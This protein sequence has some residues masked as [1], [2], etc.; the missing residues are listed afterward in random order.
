VNEEQLRQAFRILGSRGGKAPRTI[1]DAD[2]QRRRDWA[3]GLA[4]IRKAKRDRVNWQTCGDCDPCIGGRPDQCAISPPPK[5]PKFT[6]LDR[7]WKRWTYRADT[8]AQALAQ[9]KSDGIDAVG[10][11]AEASV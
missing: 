10:G 9:A 2:R 11:K 4:A 5:L 8:L 6:V 7:M 3:K 1:T